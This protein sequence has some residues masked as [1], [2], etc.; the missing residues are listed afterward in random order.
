[1]KNLIFR[2]GGSRKKQYIG[3]GGGGDCIKRGLWTV[4]IFKRGVRENKGVGGVGFEAE[5]IPQST[6]CLF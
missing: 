3:G 1:M 5:L 6:P 4:S 2:E